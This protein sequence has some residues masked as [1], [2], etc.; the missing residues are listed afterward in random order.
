MSSRATQGAKPSTAPGNVQQNKY[1]YFLKYKDSARV[2]FEDNVAPFSDGDRLLKQLRALFEWIAEEPGV[3]KMPSRK[4]KRKLPEIHRKFPQLSTAFTRMDANGDCWLEWAE[5][6]D[7]CLKD[8]RLHASLK[9]QLCICVYGIDH[10]GI[11]RYKELNDPFYMCETGIAPP[12]LPWEVA[13]VVE[14]RIEGLKL[15]FR[16]SPVTYGGMPV[17]PGNAIASPPFRAAGVVGFLRFWPQGYYP[18]CVRRKKAARPVGTELLSSDGSYP[19]PPF[20][21]WC[22][23]GACVPNGTHLKFRF[24][25][26]DQ[27]SDERQFYWQ[28]CTH[29]CQL[30]SPPDPAPPDHLVKAASADGGALVVGFEILKNL[31]HDQRGHHSAKKMTTLSRH[32]QRP[33]LGRPPSEVERD[34]RLIPLQA[35][36]KRMSKSSSSPAIGTASHAC[37]FLSTEGC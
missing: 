36:T 9:R 3:D 6:I 2:A 27:Y 8:T 5:F 22:C 1:A 28:G 26:A 17:A 15:S 18:A 33:L 13:H 19:M 20:D 35:T 24:Y 30:W 31:G 23:I 7:F 16:G 4:F 11:R 37:I 25:I 14:W 21:T 12:L 29:A 10:D 34:R 32:S